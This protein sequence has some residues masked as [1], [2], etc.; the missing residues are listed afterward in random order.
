MFY[1]LRGLLL[2]AV[3]KRFAGIGKL[4]TSLNKHHELGTKGLIQ[5]F[6][7]MVLKEAKMNQPYM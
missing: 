5:M 6:R 3:K 2:R 4:F 7:K 1:S